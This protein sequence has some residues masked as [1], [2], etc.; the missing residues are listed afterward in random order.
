LSTV[1]FANGVFHE[2]DRVRE[3]VASASF[4]IAADGGSRHCFS[5]G[6]RPDAAIGDFDSLS[7]EELERLEALGTEVIRHP[8]RKDYTDL[9]L[10]LQYAVGKGAQE[11]LVLAALG[12]RWDQTLANLLLP[13]SNAFTGVVIRLLDGEQEVN[14]IRSGQELA[15][16]GR[17]GDT[18]SLIPLWGDA[19]G[20]T[21]QG[22]E[23]PLDDEVLTFGSTRGISNVMTGETAQVHLK[24][25]LLAAVLIHGGSDG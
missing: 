7:P 15:L 21:T 5:M 16:H 10:A 17:S 12:K 8:A 11:V 19:G 13:A 4:I 1:I 2:S 9:E 14:L 3:A 25:G 23:Y 20:I 18:V 22:L 6:V 24:S